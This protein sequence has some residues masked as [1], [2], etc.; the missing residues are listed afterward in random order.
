MRGEVIVYL[1]CLFKSSALLCINIWCL[2]LLTVSWIFMWHLACRINIYS[3][4]VSDG[5]WHAYFFLFF[6]SQRIE[7]FLCRWLH[8]VHG[9]YTLPTYISILHLQLHSKMNFKIPHI[10]YIFANSILGQISKH[11]WYAYYVYETRFIEIGIQVL[12]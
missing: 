2:I 11:L 12:K 1:T 4:F 5:K 8:S 9:K 6:S 7:R 3:H 10:I